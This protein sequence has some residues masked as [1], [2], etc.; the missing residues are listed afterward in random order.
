M[1]IGVSKDGQWVVTT[2]RSNELV[3]WNLSELNHQKVS[4]EA[5]IYSAFFVGGQPN[6]LW[7]DLNNN[8]IGKTLA[9]TYWSSLNT[10]QSMA[11]R[12]TI[13]M[14]ATGLLMNTGTCF[15][16]TGKAF[17]RYSGTATA[18]ASS[19]PAN[20]SISAC[21]TQGFC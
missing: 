4:G 12:T 11:T 16:A 6:Y 18:P 10:F 20:S 5:N 17:P 7:Q 15:S 8:V 13:R 14:A 9:A 2:H 21:L 3:L 19:A 1:A